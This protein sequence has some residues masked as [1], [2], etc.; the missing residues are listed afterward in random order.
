MDS[1]QGLKYT[2]YDRLFVFVAEEGER[3]GML[4]V[5]DKIIVFHEF[6]KI[7]RNEFVTELDFREFIKEEFNHLN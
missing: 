2:N 6:F 5:N 1:E 7:F 4:N 3:N